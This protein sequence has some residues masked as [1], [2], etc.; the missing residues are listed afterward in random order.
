MSTNTKNPNPGRFRLDD[1]A[2]GHD[3]DHDS[4]ICGTCGRKFSEPPKVHNLRQLTQAQWDALMSYDD[5]EFER[6]LREEQERK[7]MEDIEAELSEEDKR[8]IEGLVAGLKEGI[9]ESKQ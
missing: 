3:H 1:S 7:E 4:G 8:A 2:P 9:K 5:E 6:L